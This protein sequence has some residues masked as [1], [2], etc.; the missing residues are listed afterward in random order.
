MK[1]R[2]LANPRAT[3]RAHFL[4]IAREV[5]GNAPQP[6]R[7]APAGPKPRVRALPFALRSRVLPPASAA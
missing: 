5:Q 1:I 2:S 3:W 6:V 7:T 4:A